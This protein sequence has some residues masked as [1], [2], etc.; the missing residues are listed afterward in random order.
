MSRRRRVCVFMCRWGRSRTAC[1]CRERREHASTRRRQW[2]QQPPASMSVQVS[3]L[4]VSALSQAQQT[5]S[6][7]GAGKRPVVETAMAAP[8]RA[9]LSAASRCVVHL[10]IVAGLPSATAAPTTPTQAKPALLVPRVLRRSGWALCLLLCPP[11]QPES[12][13][14]HARRIRPNFNPHLSKAQTPC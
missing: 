3:P 4:R 9:G 8:W 13:L 12:P 6:V 7:G 1:L 11:G 14:V 5:I 10:T 2:T